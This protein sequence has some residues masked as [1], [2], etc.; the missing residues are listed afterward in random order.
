MAVYLNPQGEIQTLNH[1]PR[2][3]T[4]EHTVELFTELS[5]SKDALETNEY[6]VYLAKKAEAQNKV[7]GELSQKWFISEEKNLCVGWLGD[8]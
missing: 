6:K 2:P 5:I 8:A 3:E 4:S 7:N 1:Q